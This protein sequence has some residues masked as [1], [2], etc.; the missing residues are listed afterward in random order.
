MSTLPNPAWGINPTNPLPVALAPGE[1][2]LDV[3]GVGAV[4]VRQSVEGAP[5]GYVPVHYTVALDGEPFLDWV[6]VFVPSLDRVDLDQVA[7][8]AQGVNR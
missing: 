5:T 1:L 8:V 6:A 4:H 3:D 2:V 7:H